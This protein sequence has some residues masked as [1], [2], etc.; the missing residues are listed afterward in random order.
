MSCEQLEANLVKNI[1]CAAARE[2]LNSK[3]FL[4]ADLGHRIAAQ[5]AWLAAGKCGKYLREKECVDCD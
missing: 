5:I 4:G 3:C 2:R 1:E